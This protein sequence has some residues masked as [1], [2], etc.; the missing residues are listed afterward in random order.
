MYELLFE[1]LS[2]AVY[3]VD[4]T[5]SVRGWTRIG[6]TEMSSIVGRVRSVPGLTV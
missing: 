1:Y 3:C 5:A 2:L 6:K 4:E